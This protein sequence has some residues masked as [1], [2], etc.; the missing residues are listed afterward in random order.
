MLV[1]CQ[2]LNPEFITLLISLFNN[3]IEQNRYAGNIV[4]NAMKNIQLRIVND[5]TCISEAVYSLSV[6][7]RILFPKL[8]YDSWDLKYSRYNVTC[9]DNY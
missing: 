1:R 7:H 2:K 8:V 6:Q 4:F 3:V 9:K 5:I